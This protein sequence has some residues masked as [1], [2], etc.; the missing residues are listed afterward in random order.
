MHN[1]TSRFDRLDLPGHPGRAGLLGVRAPQRAHRLHQPVRPVDDQVLPLDQRP[2]RGRMTEPVGR[3]RRPVRLD[4]RAELGALL[5]QG[6]EA[7]VVAG[8]LDDGGAEAGRS[9]PA[10]RPSSAPLSY[11]IKRDFRRRGAVRG[12]GGP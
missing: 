7:A 9:D 4:R 12:A 11:P 1:F 8:D 10:R 2:L 3:A 5:G 6:H